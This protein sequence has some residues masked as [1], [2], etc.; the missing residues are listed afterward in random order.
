MVTE[1]SIRS[2]KCECDMPFAE[3]AAIKQ[4]VVCTRPAIERYESDVL[5]DNEEIWAE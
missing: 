1:T 3:S 2:V 4:V 5:E